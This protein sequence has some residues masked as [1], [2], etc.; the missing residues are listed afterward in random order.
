MLF[1]YADE[2][3]V[4]RTFELLKKRNAK[5]E[6][7]EL[8]YFTKF[9]PSAGVEFIREEDFGAGKSPNRRE[10]YRRIPQ[11]GSSAAPLLK[12]L[13]DTKEARAA[14]ETARATAVSHL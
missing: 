5:A 6:I 1:E 14:E 11:W 12:T 2:A 4:S 3:T 10:T 7:R 9:L 13:L 8:L